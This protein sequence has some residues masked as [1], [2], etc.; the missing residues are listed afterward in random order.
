MSTSLYVSQGAILDRTR[1]SAVQ[2]AFVPSGAVRCLDRPLFRSQA[3]RDLG[4]LLDV[5]AEVISWSCLP[6]ELC[7]QKMSHIPDFAVRLKR[8]TILVDALGA[9]RW[10]VTA[11]QDAGY[12]YEGGRY[13]GIDT[14]LRLNR[15]GFAGDPNS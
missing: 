14:T 4:C 7:S 1:L 12:R 3:A 11:A 13:C 9:P 6:L 15:P 5:D 10:V 8:G 2:N